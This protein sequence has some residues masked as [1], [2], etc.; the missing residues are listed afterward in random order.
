MRKNFPTSL[1]DSMSM[2][3]MTGTLILDNTLSALPRMS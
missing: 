3:A 1:M 2:G